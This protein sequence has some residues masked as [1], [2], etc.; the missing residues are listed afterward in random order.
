MRLCPC[1]NSSFRPFGARRLAF[2]EPGKSSPES[3]PQAS[4][5]FDDFPEAVPQAAE[6]AKVLAEATAETRSSTRESLKGFDEALNAPVLAAAR[7]VVAALDSAIRVYEKGK[8]QWK[9]FNP[10]V[11]DAFRSVGFG[12]GELD[13]LIVKKIQFAVGARPIDGRY[14]PETHGKLLAFLDTHPTEE[15][16]P[17]DIPK[18]ITWEEIKSEFAQPSSSPEAP[19]LDAAWE[20]VKN[21]FGLPAPAEPP[22]APSAFPEGYFAPTQNPAQESFFPP[23]ASPPNSTPISGEAAPEGSPSA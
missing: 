22:S 5:P 8:D 4:E 17:A 23:P 1:R 19:V 7:G 18:E 9:V 20:E 13:K 11:G 16:S 10:K 3:A 15:V 14:G 6:P 2:V 21:E 12:V